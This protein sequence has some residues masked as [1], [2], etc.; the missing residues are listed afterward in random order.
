MRCRVRNFSRS[1]ST[2]ILGFFLFREFFLSLL[3]RHEAVTL[4]L[5][6]LQQRED[7]WAIVDL[8]GKAGTCE[9][10]RFQAG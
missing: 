3:R 1:L 5:D 4:T 6:H 2:S 9:P 10:Y 8:V 7:H